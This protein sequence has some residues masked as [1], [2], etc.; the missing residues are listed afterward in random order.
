VIDDRLSLSVTHSD[1]S[2]TRWGPDETDPINLPD[3]LQFS[4]SIP[5]G[6]KDLSCNLLRRIDLDYSDQTLFDSVRAYGPGNRTAWEGRMAQFPRSHGQ[7]FSITPG[8]V[9]HSAHL[10]DF[11]GF[12]EI[13]VDRDP[14]SFQECPI[15]RRLLFAAAGVSL[16]DISWTEQAGAQMISLPNQALGAN[17]AAEIVALNPAGVKISKVMYRGA[18]TSLPAG[19]TV[20][21][22]GVDSLGTSADT[23]ALTLDDTLRTQTLTTA[24]RRYSILYVRVC[25]RERHPCLRRLDPNHQVRRLRQPRAHDPQHQRRAR[26]CLRERRDREHRQPRRSAAQRA[27]G[28]DRGEHV[29]DPPSRVQRPGHARW[30]DSDRQRLPPVRVGRLRQQA[31]LLART[32]PRQA[33]VA[34]PTLHWRA[35]RPGGRHRRAG[36]QRRHR[37]VHRPARPETSGRPARRELA[38]LD[39]ARGRDR[40]HAR[41]HEHEQPG[42]SERDHP[43]LGRPRHRLHHQRRRSRPARRRVA[44]RALAPAAPRDAEP[45]RHRHAPDRGRRARV[46]GPRRRLHLDLGPPGGR[47]AP[48]HRDDLHAR[49]AHADVCSLDNTMFKLDAILERIGVQLVGTI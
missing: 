26:R 11:P 36:L 38:E 24:A 20:N 25:R 44:R 15:E 6:F 37:P 31:V 46:A 32:G 16:G 29:P 19:W 22:R 10:D 47:A 14:G 45:D 1:G 8:A 27:H 12:R 48:D 40:R 34:S 17:V 7:G 41:R 28:R 21:L 9:G 18:T 43:P 42:D 3:G 35:T 4:T 5:G 30:C 33:H 13:Y 39:R 49:H 23:Y 2:I